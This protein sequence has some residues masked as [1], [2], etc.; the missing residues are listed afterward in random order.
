MIARQTEPGEVQGAIEDIERN[1]VRGKE[2]RRLSGNFLSKAVR[3]SRFIEISVKD[4]GREVAPAMEAL[5][6]ACDMNRGIV[7]K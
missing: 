1:F 5:S 4:T 7:G 6:V 2:L 3:G